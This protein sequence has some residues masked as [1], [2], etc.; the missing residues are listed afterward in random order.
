MQGGLR[1]AH[2]LYLL[3]SQSE[4]RDVLRV[5]VT[6]ARHGASAVLGVRNDEGV[7]ARAA[8]VA[9]ARVVGEGPNL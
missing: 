8:A 7:E 2:N 5:T 3:T 4:L 9:A 6:V 1:P